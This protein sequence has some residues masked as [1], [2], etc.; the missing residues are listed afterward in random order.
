MGGKA[1]IGKHAEPSGGSQMGARGL[2]RGAW[3]A[4]GAAGDMRRPRVA[5]GRVD[6]LDGLR[7]LAIA[8][9]IAYHLGVAWLPSGHM[10][11]VMFLVLTG[12]LVTCSLLR[13]YDRS[14]AVSLRAFWQRRL[15]RLWPALVAMVVLVALACVAFNHVLLTKMRPDIVPSLLGFSNWYYVFSGSSYF[16][17]IGPPSPLTH[18]WYI[19]IDVQV[20]LV[21]PLVLALMLRKGAGRGAIA[22]ACACIA[23]V[24]CV[25]M[26]VLYDPSADPSRVYY[27]TDT[28]C[29]AVL[30]GALLALWWPLGS[31]PRTGRGLVRRL[32][33]VGMG[34]A[35]TL[36]LAGLLSIMVLVPAT[37]PVLY[38]G[39]MV[40]V[41]ALTML[42]M[43]SLMT[44]GSFI[45]RA[46]SWRPLVWLGVRSYSLYLWHYPII[47]LL[48]ADGAAPWWLKL[49]A[50]AASLV[51]MVAS[52]RLVERPFADGRVW[53]ALAGLR[54]DA[55]GSAATGLLPSQGRWSRT[56]ARQMAVR[57][58]RRDGVRAAFAMA[59]AAA[60][61][62][63]AAVGCLVVPEATLVPEE[64][65]VS[66][67]EAA[68]RGVDLAARRGSGVSALVM[69]SPVGPTQPEASPTPEPVQ[70]ME[71]TVE[72]PTLPDEYFALRAPA[73]E[74]AR[75]VLDPVLIGD[76]VPGDTNFYGTF[77]DGFIDSF[78]GRR[79][80]QAVGVFQDYLA[81]G[82]VGDVVVFAVF[83]NTTPT[84]EQLE[85]LVADAGPDRS[86]YLV[87][88]VNPDGFQD[89]ANQNLMDCA[90]A[91]DNVTY[92][93]WP[94]TCAGWEGVYL[95]PDGTHL[96]PEGGP[97]YLDMI[98]RAIG[99][100]ML[101]A[102]GTAEPI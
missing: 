24:S 3:A 41:C 19:G 30:F 34:V 92:V 73:E 50:V 89:V 9:I 65:I 4:R 16:E 66:T 53:R 75:G 78:I 94:A 20:C 18:L 61:A 74:V 88:T 26:G 98:A 49:V 40:L 38:R 97:V 91:H 32:G 11:V 99:E 76:S 71:P 48:D 67:G 100:D 83:S 46:F 55:G 5:S 8:S 59:A 51:A 37:S 63:A 60:T 58:A 29:F 57:H 15:S 102:G 95:Y 79:P 2:A 17:Q 70:I 82:A 72:R 101:M 52:W 12:Y 86:V 62:M 56:Q 43:A 22:A 64:A 90:A 96:T 1:A 47:Q 33:P 93:D 13:Q 35:G 25:L 77:P 44:P 7:T 80:D 69:E 28:R 39:G 87:G 85:Q 31:A 23:V 45:A 68:D 27:G 6:T 21:W 14:G 42:L 10:G 81:Q 84:P 36:S 54:R